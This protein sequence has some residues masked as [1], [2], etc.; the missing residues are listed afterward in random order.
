MRKRLRDWA[1][2]EKSFGYK[3]SFVTVGFVLAFGLRYLL[4]GHLP[5]GFPYLTF[6]PAVILTTFFAGIRAGALQAAL[7]GLA[8]W[9]F[10]IAPYNSFQL[11]GLTALALAF[12]IFIVT[13]DIV[14]IHV[15]N[16]SL[17]RLQEERERSE[18]LARSRELMFHE[19]QHRVS[20]NL[21]VVGSLLQ[22]QRRKVEDPAA[23]A[24]LD[25]AAGRLAVV[26]KIQRRLHDPSRQEMDFRHFF[27]EIVPDIIA[28]AGAEGR[29]VPRF[30]IED[31]PITNDQAIP[32]ALI[33]TECVSNAIEHNLPH[34]QRIVLTLRLVREGDDD[35]ALEVRDDGVGLPEGFDVNRARSLG[36]MVARQFAMQL[37]GAL[38]MRDTD[39]GALARVAFPLEQP[40]DEAPDPG[41]VHPL[42]VR[43]I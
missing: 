29:V 13:T 24:A 33:A 8:S 27:E 6:F 7:G 4:R 10:F 40:E 17:A 14:L 31:L 5:L 43:T 32:L 20:N 21:Q 9:Y 3:A 16:E 42:I 30:E 38:E 35:G 2:A 18:T 28:A 26:A 1:L 19:L 11:S 37:G 22:L 12:Y 36:L 15:M 23:Q 34:R 39:P 41:S 25:S